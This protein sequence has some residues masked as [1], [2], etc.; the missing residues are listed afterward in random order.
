[1]MDYKKH[2]FFLLLCAAINLVVDNY[3]FNFILAMICIVLS[4]GLIV[5]YFVHKRYDKIY[6]NSNLP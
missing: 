2:I 1:M 6:K 4:I 5:S 3:Y